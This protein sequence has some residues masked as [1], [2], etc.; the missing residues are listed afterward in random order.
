[1]QQKITASGFALLFSVLPQD[2]LSHFETAFVSIYAVQFIEVCGDH[3][4]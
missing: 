4:G 1:M 2:L 3:Y